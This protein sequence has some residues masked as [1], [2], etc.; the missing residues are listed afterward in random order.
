MEPLIENTELYEVID[1]TLGGFSAGFLEYHG[2][3]NS[4]ITYYIQSS[5][6]FVAFGRKQVKIEVKS[7][8]QKYFQEDNRSLLPKQMN[9][10]SIITSASI[11]FVDCNPVNP[12][13][14]IL[15]SASVNFLIGDD[16]SQWRSY[17]YYK[18]IAFYNLY[19]HIDL[20]YIIH[21]GQ[22]KY[23][24]FVYPG[25]N[26]EDIKLRWIGPVSLSLRPN[27]MNIRLKTSTNNINI[28]DTV[29]VSY[30]SL[31]RK[32]PIH[33]DFQKLDRTTYGFKISTY[34]KAK[35]LII[36][37][38]LLA[39]STYISGDN[40]DAAYSIARDSEGNIYITGSTSSTDFPTKNY[41]E[42]DDGQTDVFVTKLNSTGNGL[43]YSTYVG[44]SSNE[45]GNSIAIDSN[46]NAYVTGYTLSDDFPK[47][48]SYDDTRNGLD[49]FVFKLSSNG[50]S[51]DYCTYI[52]GNENFFEQ[53]YAIAV[54]A[55]GYAY[56]T[57]ET[58]ATDASFPML[59]AFQERTNSSDVRTDA[60]ILKLNPTGTNLI[61]SS[62]LGGSEDDRGNAIAIDSDGNAYITGETKSNDFLTT[63]GTYDDGNGDGWD[64]YYDVFVSKVGF[65]GFSSELLKSTYVSGTDTFGD[66][67]IG[68]GIAIDE[69]GY[70]FVTGYTDGND[71]PVKNAYD[72]DGHISYE[73]A[74]V[75]K[76]NPSFD[77]FAYSTYIAGNHRD[78]G[79]AIALDDIGNAYITGKTYSTTFPVVDAFNNTGDQSTSY[80]DIFVCK[81]NAFGNDLGYSTYISG[82]RS[83]EA[84]GIVV[85]QYYT[86]YICGSTTSSDFPMVNAYAGDGVSTDVI[87]TA[88]D[89]NPPNINSPE[90][91]TYDEG[92]T[93]N[94]I[95][96][97]ANDSIPERYSIE[98][99]SGEIQSEDW[100]SDTQISINVDGLSHGVYNYTIIIWDQA[101]HFSSDTV[102]VTVKEHPYVTWPNEIQ[103]L[104]GG[105]TN[106][107]EWNWQPSITNALS[108]E[109]WFNDQSQGKKTSPSYS[110]SVSL[111]EGE[112]NITILAYFDVTEQI[113]L[114]EV[115]IVRCDTT[116]PSITLKSPDENGV[117]Q[118]DTTITIEFSSD[119]DQ[120]YYYWD[121]GTYTLTT[122]LTFDLPTPD[123]SHQLNI[124]AID[125]ASNNQNNSFSF[126]TDDTPPTAEIHGITDY[127]TVSGIKSIRVVPYDDNDI[128]YVAFYIDNQLLKKE[129]TSTVSGYVWNWK[130]KDAVNGEHLVSIEVVDEAGNEF[131]KTFTITVDNPVEN[132][133]LTDEIDP[134]LVLGVATAIV[135]PIAGFVY[136]KSF[137][138][139]H[140]GVIKAYMKKNMTIKEIAKMKGKNTRQIREILRK[141]KKLK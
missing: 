103:N 135:I 94:T 66:N 97:F 53:G 91:I 109:L 2:E 116:P 41:I 96:W 23:E 10:E 57:G 111:D 74:F 31:S 92:D 33:G 11:E 42:Q 83:D 104:K 115:F 39:F 84:Y 16:P 127:S 126:I 51:L 13:A 73:D 105:L 78:Y 128:D 46:H 49:I 44:G 114:K 107:T 24:F 98:K 4:E 35:L 68:Q 121:D 14:E 8:K 93:G 89:T 134:G 100:T 47:V 30:Q 120:W 7:P 113:S 75:F 88:I 110:W 136:Y 18:Q 82:S 17:S 133:E 22:L 45:I 72:P 52:G 6:M 25:G 26:V 122:D 101:G 138:F 28:I 38:T 140:R 79:E 69:D 80:Y 5:G 123:G 58:D 48:N 65:D 20:K 124:K 29:P 67:E 9:K 87:I 112:N 70:V 99:N 62:Y 130:T 63:S 81:L 43:I 106:K 102:I 27:G 129:T 59:N 95:K 15:T 77:D 85:D 36:D 60:F 141:A 131:S 50:N 71:W 55:G 117:Y 125:Y 90:D 1:E 119:T 64:T 40:S 137:N 132:G 56:V 86:A 12:V 34:D 118:H 19:N 54:D 76:M 3:P 61:Y 139:R 32:R 108:M 21:E 37:P